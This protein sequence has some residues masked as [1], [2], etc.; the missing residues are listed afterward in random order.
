MNRRGSLNL[1]EE[2]KEDLIMSETRKTNLEKEL[3]AQS[4]LSGD[5]SGDPCVDI[6][7][8]VRRS[9]CRVCQVPVVGEAPFCKDHEPPVP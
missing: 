5:E 8:P 6:K 9:L 1:S 7:D 4:N 2:S 3:E